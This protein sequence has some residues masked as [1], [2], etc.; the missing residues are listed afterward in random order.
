MPNE[1]TG[2]LTCAANRVRHWDCEPSGSLDWLPEQGTKRKLAQRR[3]VVQLVDDPGRPAQLCHS[4]I[5]EQL[6]RRI[7]NHLRA[8]KRRFLNARFGNVAELKP[9]IAG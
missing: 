3:S 6:D 9:E 7:N 8:G 2:T 5:G 4:A 1:G